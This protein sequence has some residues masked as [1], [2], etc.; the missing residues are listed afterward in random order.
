MISCAWFRTRKGKLIDESRVHVLERA[1]PVQHLVII[2]EP[3]RLLLEIAA[4]FDQSLLGG[5]LLYLGIEK[6]FKACAHL[7]KTSSTLPRASSR[8]R[9]IATLP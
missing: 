4:S 2:E 3:E 8:I 7:H 5:E 1:I 6:T 9:A